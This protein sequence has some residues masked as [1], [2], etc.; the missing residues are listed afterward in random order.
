MTRILNEEQRE[1]VGGKTDK[2]KE[3]ENERKGGSKRGDLGGGGAM[4]PTH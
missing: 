3:R 1:E 2:E 4:N